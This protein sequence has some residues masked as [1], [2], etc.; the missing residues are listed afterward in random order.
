MMITAKD[1]TKRYGKVA[2]LNN[3]SFTIEAGES[4]AL[5]GAN[6]AGK[7]TTLRCLLGV[8]GFEG[9][10][11]VNGI[12]VSHSGKAARA[13]IGYVPQEAVFY[14]MS[15][16]ETLRFYARLKRTDF[17]RVNNLLEQMN[18]TVH[19][20][21][22]VNMLSGGMKQRLALTVALLA[23]PPVLVLDEPTAN[24]DVQAQRDFIHTVQ[25]LNHSGKTIVF[26]SHR[27]DEVVS[28]G[29][30]VLVL[31]QG[32]LALECRPHELAGKLGLHRWLRI[33]VG[34]HHTADT[35]KVLSEHGYTTMPNGR[36]VYVQVNLTGKIAPLRSLELANIPVEDFDLIE[37]ELVVRGE[38]HD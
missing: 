27:I 6:G 30:R 12:D 7:T 34:T 29:S 24:L 37:G 25:M 1:L 28:L 21:K 18:L 17:D 38:D 14:D 33:W 23:D 2:A 32:R 10:L 15:V 22:R 8:Q 20:D 5:W 35:L 36:S 11:I 26:S 9:E 13:A 19:R 3:V 4:V 31:D 16:L